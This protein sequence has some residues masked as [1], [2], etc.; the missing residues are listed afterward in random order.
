MEY[1][2]YISVVLLG[3]LPWLLSCVQKG[4]VYKQVS[5]IDAFK[6]VEERYQVDMAY[7]D[8]LVSGLQATKGDWT[9]ATSVEQSLLTL[10]KPHHLMFNEEESGQYKITSFDTGRRPVEG[11]IAQLEYLSNFYNDRQ[12]WEQR[13]ANLRECIL[14]GLQL[15]P[16]P[17]KP[18]SDPIISNKRSMNGYTI[19]NVAI[20]TLPGVFVTGSLYRPAEVEGKI[21]VIVSPNGHFDQGRYRADQ[22]Y[23]MAT[24]ARMGAMVFSYDMFG[25]GE[26]ELQVGSEAHRT[27][28][29]MTIQLLNGM[30]VLDYLTALDNADNDRVG[31]TGG[32]GGGSQTMML[33]ALDE[34]I[35]VSVPVVMLSSYFNGGCPC[36]TGRPVHMCGGGT[37][38]VE[39]AAMAA[40][41][42]QL[43]ISD[44]N[45]WTANVPEIAYP[46]LQK[47]YDYYGKKQ[48]VQNEHF[49]TEG[50]DYGQSK[51]MAMYPFLARHL[52][53]DLE[54]VMDSDGKVDESDV[55]IEDPSELYVFGNGGE[56]LPDRAIRDFESLQVMFSKYTGR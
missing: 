1:R 34:R 42:P 10:L 12:S 11:G 17:P 33:T 22:Q 50:H 19:Q 6:K 54:K 35:D 47:I 37:N 27:P 43:V 41:R 39:V 28:M 52:E 45:D 51:R 23:R 49:P 15:S 46:Y 9:N 44:G 36:E 2:N 8:T 31:I 13:K 29:A 18:D 16:M 20:E 56:K 26:S 7:A 4:N 21:P 5:L 30:R 40:P 38:N 53:L 24:L 55:V 25:W 32:S 14:E 48:L 3:L